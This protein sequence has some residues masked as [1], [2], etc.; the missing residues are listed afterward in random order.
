M[1]NPANSSMGIITRKA[2]ALFLAYCFFATSVWSL[3]LP[4]G[5][6][7]VQIYPLGAAAPALARM[8]AHPVPGANASLASTVGSGLHAA[9]SSA[10]PGAAEVNSISPDGG[11][12]SVPSNCTVHAALP[13][14]DRDD[15]D[16]H[17]GEDGEHGHRHYTYSD[18]PNPPASGIVASGF[19]IFGP[20]TYVRTTG[21]PNQFDSSITVP[22][23]IAQP[24]YLHVQNGDANKKHR[25]SSAT[26]LIN[27]VTVLD[28]S[29]FNEQVGSIDCAVSLPAQTNL[30]VT[31]ASKPGSF[32]IINLLG[33]NT[34]HTS[35]SL[36]IAAPANGTAVNTATPHLVVSYN[37]L[38]GASEPAASGVNTET[39]KVLLDGID[40]TSLFTRRPNEATADLPA[41]MALAAGPHTLTASITDNAANTAQA[42]SQF[43]VD[44]TPITI[45]VVTPAAGAFLSGAATEVKIAYSDNLPIDP[46]TL[47]V[48]I[49]GVDR[50]ALFTAT[51]T[52]ATA[53]LNPATDLQQGANQIVATIRDQ[54]GNQG[55]A[56]VAFNVDAV[57]PVIT[58]LHPLPSSRHGSSNVEYSVQFSDD[59]AIDLTSLQ[60]AVDGNPL[61]VTPT[62]TLATGST[63]LADGNHT[64]TVLI[65]DKAGNT[66]TASSTF[67]VDTSAPDIHIIQPAS[68]SILNVAST[69]LEVRYGVNETI[70]PNTLHVSLDGID[71]TAGL[72]VTA[73]SATGTLAT[74]S[75]G[76]HTIT[77]QIA[78]LTGNIG[79]ASATLLIDTIKPV[80]TIASPAGPVNTATP[81]ALAHY[82]DAG[83]GINTASVHVFVDGSDVTAAFSIGNDSAAGVI[84][85]GG[86]LS[87]GA[88]QLRV[89]VADRATNVADVSSSFLVDITPPTAVFANPANNSFINSTQPALTLDYSDAG[90]GINTSAIRIFLQQGSAAETEITSQFTIGATEANATISAANPLAAGTYHLRA[91]VTDRAG[92]TTSA[93]SAFE[94]DTT[95]PVYTI[96][97][98]AANSFVNTATPTFLVTYHDDGSGV[99][100]SKFAIRVDGVDRTNRMT[101]GDQL[102]TG[103]L[104]PGDALGDGTH[105]VEVTV[106]DRAGNAAAIVPQSFLVDT[107]PPVISVTTSAVNGITNNNL[108][109]ITVSYS[110]AGSGID[111]T[112]FHLLIDGVDHTAEFTVTATGATGAP[113]LPLSDGAHQVTA[114]ISDLAGNASAASTASFTLDTVPPQITIAQPVD[115]AFSN[116]ASVV[117]T[118][119]VTDASPVTITVEG[120]AV[121]LL[122]GAFTSPAVLLGP[123]PSQIIHVLA[124]D[125]AGNTSTATVTVNIDRAPPTII[126]AIAP[127]PT[128]AGWNNT[129]VT[130]NFICTDTGSG[131]AACSSPVTLATEGANQIVT[132]TATDRVGNTA[133]TTVTVNIDL[134]P[135]LIA[136]AVAP[137]PN[138]AGWNNTDVVVS[139]LCSDSLSGIAVCPP[140]ATV[141]SEGANVSVA[142]QAV[143]RAGNSAGAA[144]LLKIDKTPPL[145]TATATP[146]AN[147]AGWN[148][149]NVNVTFAC[150]DALSGV[151]GCPQP[152]T[153]ASEGQNQNISAQ[154]TDI[155]G[156]S[157]TGSISLSIDK[158]APTIVQLVAPDHIS[159][160]HGGQI[161]VTVNDNFVVAEVVISVN[162]TVL[163]TFSGGPYQA[164]LQVPTGSNPGDTLTVTAQATDAAG[165]IQ[166]ATRGV[167]VAADGV[168]VGQVL[169]D[170][171]S[172][173][174]QGAT[175]QMIGTATQSDQ[176]D[177]RGRYSLPASDSHLFV[178]A[179]SASPATTA[180]EREVFVQEGVGTVPVDA[181]LTPLASPVAMGSSG[182]TLNAGNIQVLVPAGAALP[183][184]TFQLTPLSGQGLPGLLPLGWS[185]VA[186]LDL[187]ASSAAAN[188]S[189]TF[190]HLSNAA[191]H[192]V[193]Y[194]P[195]LHAWTMVAPSLLPVSGNVNAT[196]PAPG[197]YAL[198]VPDVVDPPITIP[199]VGD[200]LLGV[201]VQ[202][203]SPDASSSGSLSPSI[204]PPSGGTS[205]ATLGIQSPIYVPSG[206]VIQ[207]NVSEKFSL[208]SGDAVSE[209][210]RSED[211]VLYNALAPA[212]S[213]LGA[214]FPVKPA[215]TFANTEL[216]T[217]KVHLDILA[218]REG[219]RGQPGGSDPLT[220]SDGTSTLSVPG[221]ALSDD[222]AMSVESSA[223]EDFI[224]VS[225]TLSALQEILV[226]FSGETLNTPAQLSISASGLN[227]A[228]TFLLTKV[229]RLDGVPRIV[230]VALAQ[231]NGTNLVSVSSPGLPGVT[232]GGEY[233]FYEI[234]APVGFAQGTVSSNAGP[235]QALV[236]TDSLPIV[237]ITGQNGQYIVPALAGTMNLRAN[238]SHTALAGS[239]SVVVTAGQTTPANIVLVGVAT[240]AV[241]S[242]ADGALGVPVSTV[243]TI[244]TT[245]PLNPQSILQSNLVLLKGTAATGTPIPV[246]P[247]VL[248]SS[249]TVLS[250]AP[251]SNLDPAAQYTIQVSGLADIFGGA[252]VV[253]GSI[254]TTKAATPLNFDP[255][256][257]TYS[258]PDQDGE[259]HVTA[260]AGTLPP[261]TTVLIVDQTN[262]IVL[263]LTALN[264]G[265]VTGSFPGTIND[266]LLITVTSPLGA[267]AT[268]TRSQFVAPDGT[269]AVGSGGGTVTGPGGVELRIPEG[270]LNQA[271][272]FKIETFGPELFPERPDLPGGTFG[273]GLKI[274]SP[275]KPTFK[276]EVKLVFPKP[277]DAPD[278]AFF[279][280]YR[281]MTNTDGTVTFQTID[282]GLVEGE[283]A[284]AKVVTASPPFSGYSDSY[285]NLASI[286][287]VGGFVINSLADQH[288]TMMWTFEKFLIG[289]ASQD[290]VVGKVLRTIPP[291][292]GEINPT[293]VPIPGAK[294]WRTDDVNQ[295]IIAITGSDGL[296]SMF[297]NKLG[298]G[299][300]KI[301]VRLQT[302]EEQQVDAIVENTAQPDDS[303]YSLL[304]GIY[305][306]Y[307]NIA[308][309]TIT[310][311]PATPVPPP[312]QM[313]V[314]I[315]T[316]DASN[317]RTEING[318]VPTGTSLTIGVASTTDPNLNI[319]S[320]SVN[321]QPLA[322]GPDSGGA[323]PLVAVASA[324]YVPSQA[325]TYTVTATALSPFGGPP[326]TGTK[327]FR[328]L[329]SGE[330]N[331]TTDQNNPPTVVSVVPINHA[332][333]ISPGV[334]PQIVFSEPVTNVPGNITLADS[335]GIPVDFTMLAVGRTDSNG[336]APIFDNLQSASAVV[337]AVTLQPKNG[338][339]YDMTYTLSVGSGIVDLDITPK[340]LILFTSQFK[341]IAPQLLAT[342]DDPFPSPRVVLVDNTAYV[343]RL[344]GGNG[345]LEA[346]STKNPAFLGSAIGTAVVP[347][348]PS[349]IAGEVDNQVGGLGPYVVVS[350]GVSALP[351]PS[352]L[353]V[354]DVSD[355][356]SPVRIGVVGMSGDATQLGTV[357]R[358]V[359]KDGVAYTNTFLK[360]IQTVTLSEVVKGFKADLDAIASSGEGAPFLFNQVWGKI[361]NVSDGNG[362]YQNELVH[363]IPVTRPVPDGRGGTI[364]SPEAL[365]GLGVADYVM[366][367]QQLK[368]LAVAAGHHGIVVVDPLQESIL[369][370]IQ[371]IHGTAAAPGKLDSGFALSLAT[372]SQVPIAGVIGQGSGIDSDTQEL[373]DGPVLA[374]LNMTNPA[375]P[376]PMSFLALPGNGTDILINNS[377]AFV[378]VTE[379]AGSGTLLIDLTDL[380]HPRIASPLIPG[381]AGRLTLQNGSILYSTGYGL[382]EGG[383]HTAVLGSACGAL[384]RSASVVSPQTLNISNQL[385]WSMHATTSPNDGLVLTDVE[386]GRRYMAKEMSLPYLTMN[387][388]RRDINQTIPARCELIPNSDRTGYIGDS[389]SPNGALRA[390]DIA[391]QSRSQLIDFKNVPSDG[392][393]FALEA[394]YLLD[395]LDGDPD[396][397]ATPNVPDSCLL[398]TQR[399][400]FEKENLRPFEPNAALPTGKFFP[401]VE[402]KYFSDG[403][404][405]NS[406]TLPQRFHFDARDIGNQPLAKASSNA[407]LLT[408]DPDSLLASAGGIIGLS[409]CSGVAGVGILHGENPLE[410]EQSV[411]VIEAGKTNV[412]TDSG[413]HFIGVLR[414]SVD[415]YHQSPQPVADPNQSID[416]P[417]IGFPGCPGCVHIH[418]RWATQLE[419]ETF[420]GKVFGVDPQFKNNGGKL[421]IPGGSNQDVDIALVQAKGDSERH[422]FDF[423]ALANDESLKASDDPQPVFWYAGT[424]HLPTDKFFL[425][426]GAFSTLYVNKITTPIL[427]PITFNIEH[428]HDVDWSIEVLS[429]TT[430]ILGNPTVGVVGVDAGTLTATDNDF[431]TAVSFLKPYAVFVQLTDKVT[432]AHSQN[433]YV[434]TFPISKVT[435]P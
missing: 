187:R 107:T 266:V 171:T 21:D 189:A 412:F 14:S 378:S 160:L 244:S 219:V 55:T 140:P 105:Q 215:R 211:I 435:E 314:R 350:T 38:P 242:P 264:D 357:L 11:L 313:D 379:A 352:N 193:F 93:L 413:A 221:G 236:Q 58:I 225:S 279:Y 81:A 9:V 106:V 338:L 309:A 386:L 310:F 308:R 277:A 295:Q 53:V 92:N 108:L 227:P 148:N 322:F 239:A 156:N 375:A 142:G 155:A 136:A 203:L 18:G 41:S 254:F 269:V 288:F 263:S 305:R 256:K 120:V 1:L 331:S 371:P 432:G 150:S 46:A 122:A 287:G 232:T 85:A 224:P 237:A 65:K 173:P 186:A 285:G 259:I 387:W 61:A 333:R 298:A 260:P 433:Y 28:P 282:H 210:N 297:T 407:T 97:A 342:P 408:C 151:A 291:G 146:A 152:R 229:E 205:T 345:M 238:V 116:A 389:Q 251:F 248:S 235:V 83:S 418:W 399:Y 137:P 359:V 158:T 17:D 99:D 94:V 190:T 381:I 373:L 128:A 216:L 391:L 162:G 175:V 49:N 329:A 302:G 425:H 417:G 185:P 104:Q 22:A 246:Q 15:G 217:G 364:D 35:P 347:G 33:Q 184:T 71:K 127:A 377:T 420:I 2:L 86:A 195:A 267:T 300:V 321:G 252:V 233:V 125:T 80:L 50:S 119:S 429:I 383:I 396:N 64:L 32:L 370:P 363:T 130:V 76:S 343:V 320:L 354:Y 253:P 172:F 75:E 328:V 376:Q 39:L 161:S 220:L 397:P 255:D 165:N 169:S 100:P 4:G 325:G 66:A 36:A 303:K 24:F 176:T 339:K 427:G 388:L 324:D 231:I 6:Q 135:P 102:A 34:D 62:P 301:T 213:A 326:V 115:G 10:Y 424:G 131:I 154:A 292:P 421:F 133:Q 274:T 199:A 369:F 332:E 118:G 145:V 258:F 209:E 289:V 164:A 167:R 68:G 284:E 70:D 12:P 241:V 138:A 335:Q 5:R 37:D 79:N 117:V 283:G 273:G 268:F 101:A 40:R 299:T 124:T 121:P 87:E 366:P 380:V 88:H 8:L 223:H 60:V 7:S 56:S 307:K 385:G 20:Q 426:G 168:V 400:Q 382:A 201:G 16:E 204:V 428:S 129:S 336:V 202:L 275:E 13:T 316:H 411:R 72:T 29:A 3:A 43:Q 349:D 139:Y 344:M 207:A 226:D 78:D 414:Q 113:V 123:G 132:G 200:P 134:T 278:G 401:T 157:G 281:R 334:F 317:R 304:L 166:T 405:L 42:V 374:I 395:R 402:Y 257:I 96:Q 159:R 367:N 318:L 276:K 234:S 73:T 110:D 178:V 126:G 89:T 98:P 394:T 337:T 177:T 57:P 390:C 341:T 409:G 228:D 19:K 272:T 147:A 25:V 271:A 404:Q 430:D 293:F 109:P 372:V 47:R 54:A 67:S 95:A 365:F 143:D 348:A 245:A 243:I 315:F 358:L 180:V 249:G 361:A 84:S 294:A 206:T 197:A 77:A 212:N 31:L 261:G 346:Y 327:S 323:P 410:K 27:G 353:W 262:G 90:S 306:L 351:K 362:G 170:V 192:L 340:S 319:R 230:T 74:L 196:L 406:I 114:T 214:Q 403:S 222:T 103:T 286:G 422:P 392:K 30:H 149:T 218:G 23:W 63:I 330:S 26:I 82:S 45:Q 423:K 112:Q 290:I 194:N 69:P 312:P 59:Q 144:T 398:V 355:P 51:A 368:R 265:S 311:E 250:F 270:A 240:S 181:R 91:Q 153:V 415:N 182:L 48:L 191:M 208:K 44:L 393:T 52:Q 360:G 141:S 179:S 356:T 247:F 163:G 296:F 434:Y 384:R 280:V 188:V 174:I 198:V 419:P 416:L 183:A 111:V 431:T